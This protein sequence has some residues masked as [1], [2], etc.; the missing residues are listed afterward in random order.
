[1]NRATSAVDELAQQASP[2]VR[3]LARFGYLAKGIVYMLVGALAVRAA[4]GHDE[5]TGSRGALQELAGAPLG[6]AALAAI[7]VGLFGYVI[8]RA[9]TAIADPERDGPMHRVYAGG[10][11]IFHIGIALA[12]ARLALSGRDANPGGD[13]GARDWTATALGQPMG[14]WIVVAVAAA[15]IGWGIAQLVRAWKAKLDD[16]LELG[17]LQPR[18]RAWVKLSS[19]FGIAARGVVFMLVGFFLARA[20][21]AYDASHARDPGG[22]LRSLEQQPAGAWLLAVVAAGLFA[23]GIYELLRAKYRRIRVGNG[24]S[25]IRLERA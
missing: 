5:A 13:S 20:A 17:R 21:L 10:V 24:G 7:A 15:I 9:Y 14:R 6:T 11:A 22:A 8:W 1:M 12:A 18:T 25:R 16:Q 2:W 4:V 23:Y 19:R 3:R